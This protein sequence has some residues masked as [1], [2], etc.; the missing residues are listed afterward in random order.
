MVIKVSTLLKANTDVVV[1]TSPTLGGPL[2]TNN[3]PI[4]NGGNPVIITGNSYPLI[5]GNPGQVLT[6]DGVGTTTWQDPVDGPITLVGDITGSGI[7]PVTTTLSDTGVNAG[8]Y[9]TTSTVGIFTVNSKGRITAATN[10]PIIITPSQAGL[11]NVVNQ[12]QVINGGGAPSV[13]ED[14]GP[15]T[16]TDAIGAIYIDQAVTDGNAIYR[17]NG[18]TW[19]VIAKSPRLYNEKVNGFTAP[20]AQALDSVAIGSGAET[21]PSGTNSLAIGKQSYSRIP[22]GFVQSAGRFTNPGDAQVGRYIVRGT[23]ISP[24]AQELFVDGTGGNQR[25]VLPDD[26]TWTFKVTVT[27]HRTDIGNGH[28]GYT[29]AGVIYRNAG[30]ASTAIQGSVQ[31]TVLAESNPVW[32]INITADAINGSLKI[33]VTGEASKTIRWVALVETVEITN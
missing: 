32:D 7:S 1:D 29:A 10:A 5:A 22:G 21:A 31:K 24:A 18:A 30:V 26:S 14:V 4:V 15:P 17:F 16:G 23:T 11:N 28:A 33:S 12:L 20:V 8:I 6:T 3:F 13:R 25:I 27:A 19:D 2:T 9:G